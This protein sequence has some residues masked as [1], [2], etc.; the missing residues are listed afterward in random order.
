MDSARVRRI[1]ALMSPMAVAGYRKIRLG[2]DLD[3]GLPILKSEQ[4]LSVSV[5]SFK[6]KK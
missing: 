2:D 1:L 3:G 6:I 5:F 4:K